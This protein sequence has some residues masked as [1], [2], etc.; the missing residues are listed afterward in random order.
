MKLSTKGRYAVRL[1]LDLTLHQG[2]KPVLLKDIAGRE[3][4][5]S[6]YL[7]QLT[8]N[9]KVA[10]LI[11]SIRGAKGGFILGKPAE[12][13]TLLEIFKASEGS[14]SIV[15]CLEDASFCERSRTCV[16]RDLWLEMKESMEE[17]LNHWTLSKLAEQQRH[18]KRENQLLYSI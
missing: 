3:A 12:K 16:S 15:E 13:I 11:K 9:L 18:K 2:D 4:I 5:S 14:L 17:I 6:R 1:M 7:E 10:G 8:L